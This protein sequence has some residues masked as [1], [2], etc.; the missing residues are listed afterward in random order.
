MATEK[1]VAVQLKEDWTKEKA[2]LAFLFHPNVYPLRE[3]KKNT[4]AWLHLDQKTGGRGT[5]E[6]AII[7]PLTMTINGPVNMFDGDHP[8]IAVP[9]QLLR[10][11]I[12]VTKDWV[13]GEPEF[14]RVE[15]LFGA[16]AFLE[17]EMLM[18]EEMSNP[19]PDL[20][21]VK[22]AYFDTEIGFNISPSDSSTIHRDFMDFAY[23]KT[24]NCVNDRV[25][26]KQ[27]AK[28]TTS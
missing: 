9:W 14:D 19:L 27:S 5:N 16:T 12:R 11:G 2:S 7:T 3:V 10:I 15:K 4:M 23:Q 21:N 22:E 6:W 28:E 18:C 1:I 13:S 20:I 17:G 24:D 25:A 26:I 8:Q